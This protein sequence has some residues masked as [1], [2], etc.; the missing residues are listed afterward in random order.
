MERAKYGAAAWAH[1]TGK[2]PNAF[3]RI[4]G[5][6]AAKYLQEV[7]DSGLTVD[8]M[9]RFERAF[10]EKLGVRNCIATPGC[11]PALRPYTTL[12]AARSGSMRKRDP[13]RGRPPCTEGPTGV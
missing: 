8:M 12:R 6:N 9:G 11:T 4:M 13:I 3:P 5:P 10:A 2:L 1:L 7:V